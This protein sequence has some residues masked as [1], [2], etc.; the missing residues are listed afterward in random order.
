MRYGVVF[1]APEIPADPVAIR[2]FAQAVED[3][4]Y[5]HIL[6]FD[7]VLGAGRSSRPDWSGPYDHT[8]KFHEPFVLM[9]FLA[10]VSRSIELTTGI[11]ILPQRQTAL[12]AKQAAEVD[13]L[14]GGRLRLGVGIG[15]NAVEYEALGRDFHTRGR[16]LPEQIELLRKLWT[17]EL[18]TFE[19]SNHAIRDAGINPLPVQRPIPLWGGAF[20]PLAIERVCRLMDGFFPRMPLDDKA[21]AR[22]ARV[23]GYLDQ[24]GRNR[25]TFGIDATVYCSG[26]DVDRWMRDAERWKD[27]GATHISVQTIG[28]GYSGWDQHLD[29]L[30]RFKE[31]LGP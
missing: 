17:Q 25:A 26:R 31:T 24:H 10:A 29:A 30:R 19:G 14:S 28:Q 18:V 11:L 1:P 15:W 6:T 4:G 8:H 16:R 23:F 12:V 21:E 3:L 13:V 7:H 9:G 2:D 5:R 20:R 27:L 22:M